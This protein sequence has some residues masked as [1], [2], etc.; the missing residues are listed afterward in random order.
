MN[1]VRT[2]RALEDL[3]VP[4]PLAVCYRK[5]FGN[6]DQRARPYIRKHITVNLNGNTM[7]EVSFSAVMKWVTVHDHF[8]QL[9]LDLQER[10]RTLTLM[11]Q[12]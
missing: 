9:F 10:E 8:E 5:W 11:R 3:R 4:K 12:K 1:V 7:S 2:L 6:I